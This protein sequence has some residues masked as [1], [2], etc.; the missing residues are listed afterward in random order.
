MGAA[1]RLNGPVRPERSRVS[2][3]VEGWGASRESYSVKC[4]SVRDTLR[5]RVV[6][7]CSEEYFAENNAIVGRSAGV[8]Y[9]RRILEQ[10]FSPADGIPLHYCRGLLTP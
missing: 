5:R 7:G 2:G 3:G 8:E 9:L 1:P 4:K 10:L 6:R